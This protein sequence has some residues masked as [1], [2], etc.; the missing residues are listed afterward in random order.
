MLHSKYQ[1]NTLDCDREAADQ[2]A[3][4]LDIPP[5]VAAL[6]TSR[7]LKNPEEAQRFLKGTME[8]LADPFLLSG[9]KEAVPRIRQALDRGE[10]ILIYGDYDADGV[11]ST[12]LMI[13]LMRHLNADYEYYIPHRSKE[14]YGLHIHALE[15]AKERGVSLVITV[16]TGISAVEQIA[17]A[18]SAGMDVIVTDH[19]EPP[20]VLPEAY[21]LINPKLAHCP[22]PFKGLAGVGVAYKLASALLG[23]EVPSEWTELAALGTVAD[24]MPLV[25]ENRVLVRYGL[26]S[27][28]NSAFPGMTAL[29]KTAGWKS[30]EVTSTNV[31]FGLAPRINAS[32]RMSHAG[33]A[34]ELLT[35]YDL[36]EAELAALD[37]DIL[38]KQRQGLVE[39]IVQEA[40]VDLETKAAEGR[41]P[42]VIVVAGEGWNVGVVGIVA[43][44]ILERYY[45]PTLVL[46]IN[47]ETGECKG[48][49]RS[50]P[51]LDMYEA[52]THCADLLDHFGGHTAAAG[53]SL[54]RER[55]AEFDR[56]LNDFAS[57]VLRPDHFVP[58]MQNDLECSL[59]EI[60]LPIIE[61]LEL[62][63]PF[64]MANPC[65]RLLIRGAK[66]LECRQMGKDGKHLRLTLGQN[67]KTVEAVAFGKGELAFLLSEES[68]IDIV[69]EAAINEWNGSR[70][71]QLMIQ[72]LAVARLQVYDYRG[73]RNP[74]A[75]LDELKDSLAKWTSS[76]AETA[77]VLVNSG[78]PYLYGNDLNGCSLW[79][80]DRVVGASP[81]NSESEKAGA[82][83]IGTLFILELP[84]MPVEWNSMLALFGSLERVF[85]LHPKTPAREMLEPPSR[86]QFKGVY[87]LLRK[88][89]PE[90]H[91]EDELVAAL[92][93]RTRLSGRMLGLTLDVFEELGFIERTSGIVTVAASPPKRPLESSAR[94]R[95]LGLLAEME[96]ILLH[97]PVPQIT[98]WM[99]THIQGAS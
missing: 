17:Y 78:S 73:F 83:G 46:G 34:V 12:A 47:P 19:H 80:Y 5:L 11:S 55:L 2:L 21:A 57:G 10:R 15:Q 38:N 8:D 84:E 92:K 88:I 13:H 59:Q 30:G 75:K 1:W 49:A 76:G 36:E 18:T 62:L 74:A 45:R 87:A 44:K 53:M 58:I 29:L 16:D 24:L 97:A 63:A 86:E 3:R 60:T 40:L 43:S 89:A 68:E 31:A 98:E 71:P 99:Q 32:G 41:L 33:R 9:M 35:T 52:L 93:A 94:Y 4:Q 66:L 39:D 50:I 64:G 7:G 70:K 61:Q 14:G 90:G 69:A 26:Q 37:L 48:S 6:M 51:G 25:G 91:R 28:M 65:P 96:Q 82:E 22:Y 79:V 95:E 20:P 23:E 67:G 77:A 85:L 56:R 72:D 42:D 54:R 27:M 81:A